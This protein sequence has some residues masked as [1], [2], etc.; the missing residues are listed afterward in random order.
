MPE[1]RVGTAH[2]LK[3]VEGRFYLCIGQ[4]IGEEHHAGCAQKIGRMAGC[5]APA[6][7]QALRDNIAAHKEREIALEHQLEKAIEEQMPVV[8]LSELV[9]VLESR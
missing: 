6:E 2:G 4:D 8:P 9:D 5:T 1:F 3:S 7:A